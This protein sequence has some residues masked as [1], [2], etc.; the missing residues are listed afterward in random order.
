ME[1]LLSETICMDEDSYLCIFHEIWELCRQGGYIPDISG[2]V[3]IYIGYILRKKIGVV[4]GG[5]NE[6]REEKEQ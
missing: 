4:C 3:V 1:H 6:G 5:R 2:A